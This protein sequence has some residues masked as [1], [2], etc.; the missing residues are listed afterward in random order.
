[1]TV[2]DL[3]GPRQDAGIQRDDTGKIHDVEGG[4]KGASSERER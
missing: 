4:T 3:V 2:F 1:M